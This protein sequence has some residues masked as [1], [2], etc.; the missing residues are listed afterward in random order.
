[1]GAR[2]PVIVGG[3]LPA[4][5][6]AVWRA[7]ID[8]GERRAWWP[9]LGE[10]EARPGGRFEERWR[11][12]RREVVTA[13]TVTDVVP[14]R[15]L[16]LLWADDDWPEATDVEIELRE[17]DGATAIEIRHAGWDRLPDGDALAAAHERG[18]RAH[19]EA[20]GRHLEPPA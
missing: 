3:T 11:D 1:M 8:P 17:E 13:G 7:L 2:G 14:E 9:Q 19:V 12:G 5:P 18:W 10:L 6:A 15:G 16:T 20:L 4:V